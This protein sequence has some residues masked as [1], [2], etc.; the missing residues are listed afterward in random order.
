MRISSQEIKGDVIVDDSF[1][2]N[3]SITGNATIISGGEFILHGTCGRDLIVEPGAVVHIHGTVMGNILNN[4]GQVEIYG[5]V[6]GDIYSFSGETFVS[7]DSVI[8]GRRVNSLESKT[9]LHLEIEPTDGSAAYY[10]P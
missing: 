7:E 1:Q 5:V 3:G 2:L 10:T 8:S 4:G 9:S 6:G